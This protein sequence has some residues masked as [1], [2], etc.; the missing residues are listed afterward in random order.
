[1]FSE[2]DTNLV[3]IRIFIQKSIL[4]IQKI[5]DL[6]NYFNDARI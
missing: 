2:N 6:K 5:K 3:K 4:K 1:M